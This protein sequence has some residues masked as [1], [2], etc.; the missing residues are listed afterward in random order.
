VLNKRGKFGEKI[1]SLYTDIVIFM[2]GYFIL[3]HPVSVHT[4]DTTTVTRP[5]IFPAV[6]RASVDVLSFTA[7]WHSNSSSF[8]V[9]SY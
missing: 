1:L 3:T 4:A 8:T 2:L 6:L 7:G 5:D 9:S